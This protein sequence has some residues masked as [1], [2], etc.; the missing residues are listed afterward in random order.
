MSVSAEVSYFSRFLV[1]FI[2]IVAAGLAT[3]VSGYLIAHLSG[4]LSSPAPAPAPAPAPTPAAAVN[5]MPPSTSMLSNLPLQP[6]P[7]VF[8]DTNKQPPVP[9]QGVIAPPV[10]QPGQTMVDTKKMETPHKRVENATTAAESKQRKPLLARVRAALANV[11]AKRADALEVAPR[12][13]D[14]T[15]P[16]PAMAQPQPITA[17]TAITT[18][19]VVPSAASPI[20]PGPVRS[21]PIQDTPIDPNPLP[22]V[23][24]TSRP[25]AEPPAASTEM[26]PLEQRLR[27]DPLIGT[28][29]PPRPPMPVAQ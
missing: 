12:P 23:E 3:A 5:Q 17:P 11:E 27:R 4:T 28:A 1:K 20:I 15:R 10:E 14:V 16:S 2:E 19:P 7:P 22:T 21:G 13:A 8:V 26:S 18:P 24:I 29:D 6:P 9:Q 25:V